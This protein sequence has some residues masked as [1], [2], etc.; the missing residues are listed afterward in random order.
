MGGAALRGARVD[1]RRHTTK[2]CR[3]AGLRRCCS[4][5]ASLR[6]PAAARELRERV[7][8][9][10]GIVVGGA[11]VAG[12]DGALMVGSSRKLVCTDGMGDA[13]VGDTSTGLGRSTPNESA[14][15]DSIGDVLVPAELLTST[16]VSAVSSRTPSSSSSSHGP[17][18]FAT[19]AAVMSQARRSRRA[20]GSSSDGHEAAGISVVD[21]DIVVLGALGGHKAARR[22]AHTLLRWCAATARGSRRR[23]ARAWRAYDRRRASIAEDCSQVREAKVLTRE[24]EEQLALALQPQQC[25]RIDLVEEDARV[26]EAKGEELRSRVA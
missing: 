23:P 13:A 21:G 10:G 24:Q 17:R 18:N 16:V 8:G 25:L 5:G 12:S 9:G 7:G 26:Q 19:S 1:A 6:R 4:V 15:D 3:R 20:G 14:G 22:V 2:L 11:R